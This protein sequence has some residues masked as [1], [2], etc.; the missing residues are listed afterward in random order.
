M[1]EQSLLSLFMV[2]TITDWWLF[3]L[4]L[5]VI[6]LFILIEVEIT[7]IFIS[8]EANTVVNI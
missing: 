1:S 3:F 5:L 7:L 6:Y 2:T 8:T 4:V